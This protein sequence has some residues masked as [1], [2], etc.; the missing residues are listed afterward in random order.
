MRQ[1]NSAKL[2][3][4]K[5]RVFTSQRWPGAHRVDHDPDPFEGNDRDRNPY[6]TC[7]DCGVQ[8]RR[9]QLRDS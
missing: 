1:A 7:L 5:H 2:W 4:E 8:L 9:Q 6:H 3:S